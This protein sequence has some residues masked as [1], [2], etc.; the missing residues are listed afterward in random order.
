VTPSRTGADRSAQL[1]GSVTAIACASFLLV[2][3]NA[4]LTARKIVSVTAG[5]MS[6]RWNASAAEPDPTASKKTE[7]TIAAMTTGDRDVVS[8]FLDDLIG[9]YDRATPDGSRRD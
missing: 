4:K 6:V 3:G 1:T 2:R 8:R 9:A 5:T 7:A